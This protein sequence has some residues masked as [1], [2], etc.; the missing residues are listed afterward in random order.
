MNITI[1]TIGNINPKN[2]NIPAL[3][4][5]LDT[6]TI[7]NPISADKIIIKVPH[8]T[9]NTAP[10]SCEAIILKKRTLELT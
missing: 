8:P 10:Y 2:Y 3:S 4:D 1:I 7:I 9:P 6:I 5:P